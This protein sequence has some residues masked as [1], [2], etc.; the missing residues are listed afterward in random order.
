MRILL[1]MLFLVLGQGAQADLLS[2]TRGQWEG[3]GVLAS[4]FKWPIYVNFRSN[5]A[6]VFTPDDGCESVWYF[7][8]VTS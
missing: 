3:E 2:E 1:V 6:E 4:G 5:T 7:E 8:S